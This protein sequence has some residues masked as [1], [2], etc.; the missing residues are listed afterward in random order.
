M[1]G[2]PTILRLAI[3]VGAPASASRMAR[4]N[5]TAVAVSPKRYR[6]RGG[7]VPAAAGDNIL[8]PY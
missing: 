8:N 2:A 1:Q 4:R 3:E 7:H 6:G 5:G